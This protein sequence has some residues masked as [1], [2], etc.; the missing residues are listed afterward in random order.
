MSDLARLRALHEAGDPAAYPLALD[1]LRSRRR[2]VIDA[3]LRALEGAP[4]TDRDRPPL[5]ETFWHYDAH[6]DHDKT[7]HIRENVTRL[8]V[9]IGHPDDR[10]IYLRGLATY[11]IQWGLGEVAQ[12]LRA[13]A[14]VGLGILDREL[15]AVHAAR[16]LSELDTTSVFNGEPAVT[17]INLLSEL[18]NAL[19]IYSYLLLAG[20][21]A[22]ELGQYE[23]VG[24]ALES[25]GADFPI[26][27]Y[28]ALIDLFA[29]RDRAVV[30]MGIIS[31]IVEHRV[32]PLYPVIET[33]MITTRHDE[34]HHYAAVMMAAGRDPAL[35]ARLLRL[36]DDSPSRRLPDFIEALE[37]LPG[38]EKDDT[39]KRLR[40]RL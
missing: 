7:Q 23:V 25:L 11:E 5:R 31:H 2:E 1:L 30:S 19:P 21:D 29:P 40:A 34:L 18:N 10:D 16:L 14:L 22:I 9:G 24:R 33:I 12:N 26:A 38:P 4:L 39:L 3:A 35:T 15:A 17:A 6:A 27:Q 36:A 13:V 37:L 32:E 20:M 8:L 28:Q